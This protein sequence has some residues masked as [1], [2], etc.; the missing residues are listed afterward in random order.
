MKFLEKMRLMII[1]NVTKK[2]GFHPL[3]R[4]YIFRKTT[5]GFNLTSSAVIG[6]NMF[7]IRLFFIKL[8]PQNILIDLCHHVQRKKK[9]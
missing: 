2:T 5:G 4:R 3:F 8:K 1:L 6:L 7:D 9:H